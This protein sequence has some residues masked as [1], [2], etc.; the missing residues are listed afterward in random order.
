M[1]FERI[2]QE[3]DAEIARREIVSK[4]LR[5]HEETQ[6]KEALRIYEVYRMNGAMELLSQFMK[7]IPSSYNPSI[8]SIS[9]HDYS[10][11]YSRNY[12]HLLEHKENPLD[13][14]AWFTGEP[15]RY[16]YS[17]VTP[18]ALLIVEG[19][20][21]GI[22]VH[23]RQGFLGLGCGSSLISELSLTNN[24]K[25]FVVALEQAYHNPLKYDHVHYYW[26]MG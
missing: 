21:K 20:S 16:A 9:S 6:I 17:T 18:G 13:A 19:T 14:V 15:R 2:R 23:G 4:H 25:A 22:Y 3:I 7:A 12:I 5:T 11:L 8:N 26:S 10:F 24:P 1:P